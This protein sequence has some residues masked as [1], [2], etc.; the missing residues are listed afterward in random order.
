[1]FLTIQETRC[2]D[3]ITQKDYLKSRNYDFWLCDIIKTKTIFCKLIFQLRNSQDH[4]YSIL[5]AFSN[6]RRHVF[7]HCRVFL[8]VC[9]KDKLN[10][11]EW[12]IGGIPY[13]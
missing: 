3:K 7:I 2:I 12:I 5:K 6:E 13:H 9:G 10:N 1:M 8:R 11:N 4:F